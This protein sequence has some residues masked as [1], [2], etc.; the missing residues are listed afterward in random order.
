MFD[1][2]FIGYMVCT[3]EDDKINKICD[4][5]IAGISFE[6]TVTK[7]IAEKVKKEMARRG[8]NIDIVPAD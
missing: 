1:M 3:E 7:D 8:Y 4:K 6:E 5:I 2:N